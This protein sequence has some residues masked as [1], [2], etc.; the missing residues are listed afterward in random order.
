M[1]SEAQIKRLDSANLGRTPLYILMDKE[2]NT[3]SEKDDSGHLV[4]MFPNKLDAMLTKL[5]VNNPNFNISKLD[6]TNPIADALMSQMEK[7]KIK[8]LVVLGYTTT[9]IDGTVK[10]VIGEQGAPIFTCVT[11]PA[12]QV[13]DGF[14]FNNYFMEYIIDEEKDINLIIKRF[15]ASNLCSD[16]RLEI[17]ARKILDQAKANGVTTAEK[18]SVRH[19]FVTVEGFEV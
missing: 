4:Y 5:V 13:K 16:E 7:G 2:F 15:N 8:P 14:A 3:H 10:F 9:N 12:D 18:E 6:D 19:I 11:T 17:E 1:L